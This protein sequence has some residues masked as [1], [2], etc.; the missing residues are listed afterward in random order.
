[1][2]QV[3]SDSKNEIISAC[4][5]RVNLSDEIDQSLSALAKIVSPCIQCATCASACPVFQSD[6]EKNPRRIIYKIAHGV[7]RAVL[8]DGDFWWC[9]SCYSCESHCPQGVPLTGLIFKLKNLAFMYGK[10]VPKQYLM[11][12]EAL[13]KGFLLP[14]DRV[15]IEK[16]K[17]L[18]LPDLIQPC[19]KEIESI[20][21]AT[22][23]SVLLRK[24]RT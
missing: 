2:N 7:S 23:F 3:V 5:E 19:L 16:R 14:M 9:G 20:L 17:R 21:E 12:G 24:F 13:S 11:A 10:N 6:A 22:G 18:G 1:M 8:E 15:R 4:A